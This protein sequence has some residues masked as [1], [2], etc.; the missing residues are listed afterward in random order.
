MTASLPLPT[1]LLAALL[2][3]TSG[4]FDAAANP[5]TIHAFAMDGA[6][7]HTLSLMAGLS[8]VVARTSPEVHLGFRDSDP[9]ADPDF[10]L[11]RHVENNPGTRVV[12]QDD[13][14]WFLE[15]YKPLLSGYVLYDDGSLNQ[16]TSVAGAVGAVMVH[17][18]LVG[19]TVGAALAES[20]LE[21]IE[22]VRGRSSDWVFDRYDFN[23]EL[24]YRQQPS[25]LHQLRAHAVLNGGFVFDATGA[26]RDRYLAAQRPQSLVLGW[27]YE[28]DEQEFFS[29]ASRHNLMTVPADFLQSSAGPARW[30]VVLPPRPGKADPATPTRPDAHYVAFVMSDGDNAQWLTNTF[31]TSGRWF[32]SPHRGAFPMTFDLTPALLEINPTALKYFYDQAGPDAQPTTFVTA[33]GHGINYPSQINDIAGYVDATVQAMQRVDHNVISILDPDNPAEALDALA[34]RP[35]IAGVMFKTNSGGYADRHGEVRWS[36]GTAI[37]AVRYTLW[38]GFETPDSLTAKLNAAPRD[39]LHDPASY[40]IVNVHPW[41]DITDGHGRGDPMSNVAAIVE[42]LDNGVEV[43]TLEELFLHLSRNQETLSRSV[44]DDASK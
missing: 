32:G 9:A 7:D 31:A 13:A 23:R 15:H 19:G 22:D 33:G 41:S 2:L 17:E 8:G 14:G 44:K 18:S 37:A 29:S 6:S 11:N 21:Q 42:R 5:A 3:A 35:E 26:T 39:A 4:G 12:W 43:V 30:E 1:F 10:W 25:K 28:N 38:E 27:G 24:I 36:S 34:A 16:A 40:S 20:G